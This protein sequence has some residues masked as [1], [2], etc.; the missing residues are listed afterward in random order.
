MMPLTLVL[1]LLAAPPQEENF[2]DTKEAMQAV[3][4]V[5]I[6]KFR[7]TGTW[8]D[9]KKKGWLEKISWSFK[10][11]GADYSL[12]MTTDKSPLFRR[13]VLRY[14]LEEKRYE[15]DATTPDG[16]S[17]TYTGNR[18]GKTL[19]LERTDE[20]KGENE[21]IVYVLLRFNRYLMRLERKPKSSSYWTVVASVGCTKEGVPFVRESNGP[22]CI[23]TGGYGSM[24]VQYKGKTYYIC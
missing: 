11:K 24:T 1:T 5:L 19:T 10:I 20:K 13:V 9:R 21:R 14:N 6:G 17:S 16:K 22:K 18:K 23:V 2:K 12:R 8:N 3:Q 15:L 4:D 7:C